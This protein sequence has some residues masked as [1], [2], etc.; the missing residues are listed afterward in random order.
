MH[1]EAYEYLRADV[2]MRLGPQAYLER[3]SAIKQAAGIPVIA[4][5]NC[6]T[7]AEWVRFARQIEATGVD[8]LELNVYDIPESADVDGAAIEARHLALVAA[9]QREVRLPISVKLGSFYSSLPNFVVR[10][11]ALK[12]GGVVLFNRFF[13]PDVDIERLEL[14]PSVN[15]SRP[16]DIRLPLRWIALLRDQVACDLCLS[17]GVHDGEGAVKA[18]LAGADVFQICTV[19]YRQDPGCIG[20]IL[21]GLRGWMNRHSVGT[22]AEARGRL[23]QARAGAG[24]GYERAQY[25]KTLTALD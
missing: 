17:T 7:A 2:A 21:E 5:I 10:L 4:S 16:E 23:S 12:I 8:G 11:A 18:I 1:P 15:L 24:L 20:R 25:I 9:I 14:R 19:L 13:Q 22:L 3:V 6:T